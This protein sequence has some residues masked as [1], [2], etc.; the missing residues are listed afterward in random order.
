MSNRLQSLVALLALTS[1]TPAQEPPRG[2]SPVSAPMRRVAR[3]LDLHTGRLLPAPVQLGPT[4]LVPIYDNTCSS[5]LYIGLEPA[6]STGSAFP[7]TFGDFGAIPS[8]RF[9]GDTGCT[10]GT[11][12]AYNVRQFE[13]AYCTLNSS[14]TV[15]ELEF[16]DAPVRSCPTC[17]PLGGT[18]P[19][20]VPPVFATRL[21][22]LPAS[23][24]TGTLTCYTVN[25]AI[26]GEGFVLTGS[27]TLDDPTVDRFAWAFTMPSSTGADGPLLAGNLTPFTSPCTPCQGTLFEV[28]GPSSSAGTGAG[29]VNQIFWEDY[30]GT[31]VPGSDCYFF[32]MQVPTGTHLKL[33]ADAACATPRAT[34]CD[35]TDNALASCPCANPGRGLTGCD[36]PFGGATT[37]S[38]TGGVHLAVTGQQSA[39]QNRASVVATGFPALYSSTSSP[40][41]R[42]L[43]LRSPTLGP[44]GPTAFGD[45][46]MCLGGMPARLGGSLAT[47]CIL[48]H[49]FNHG[50][51]A[52][53]GSFY[54]QLWF[55]SNPASYC[56]PT[57][58]FSTTNG[59]TLTW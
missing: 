46:L 27:D 25:I 55:R 17:S 23:P 2:P 52:G 58:A 35:T 41:P 30:G 22:G 36:T 12:D 56:N 47:D 13:I 40:V 4:G 29:Q 43:L 20:R 19:P 8:T 1:L 31:S 18:R 14:P 42:A 9:V 24:A 45:G 59:V 15:V 39:P 3:T 37:T 33:F 49:S 21:S 7:E 28:G 57:A 11:C 38:T 44:G 32:G 5:L 10:P 6:G 34:F 54:Y 16:W 48:E 26:E 50:P 53:S 51:A